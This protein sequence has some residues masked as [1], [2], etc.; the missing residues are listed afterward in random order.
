MT[1]IGDFAVQRRYRGKLKAVIFD[2]AGTVIDYGSRA[3]AGVFVEVYRRHRVEISLAEARGPM[4]MEKRAHIEA[5]AALPAVAARWQAAHGRAIQTA[6]IDRMYDEF[7]P[8]QLACL[9]DYAELIP[10]TLDVVAACRQRGM[11]IGTSTGYSRRLMDVVEAEAKR[12]GFEP[13]AV[14]CADDVS[15]GRPAPWMCFENARRLGVWPV[16]AIVKVDDTIPGIE[17]GLNAGMWTVGIAV[18]G[19]ELGLS[20]EEVKELPPSEY[21]RRREQAYQRLQQS[22]AHFVI[23]SVADLL[24]VLDEIESRLANGEPP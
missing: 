14:V 12:R 9:A 10:G 18:S 5:L 17:A 6:D 7:L 13:D 23:D 20:E 4:G 11:K 21:E 1:S 8:L 22:G 3:P 15:G 16:A 19:N 24:P 2:W